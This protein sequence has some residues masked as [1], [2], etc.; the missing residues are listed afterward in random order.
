M[1]V[2]RSRV[3]RVIILASFATATRRRLQ[4]F[5][6]GMPARIP[7]GL[8]AATAVTSEVINMSSTAR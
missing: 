5:V 3:F 7:G 1:D 2:E 8:A 6:C 4:E